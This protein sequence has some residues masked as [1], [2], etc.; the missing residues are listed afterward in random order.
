MM[1][2]GPHAGHRARPKP[3]AKMP[4]S[5]YLRKSRSTNAG[6]A[7]SQGSLADLRASQFS[8]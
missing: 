7:S 6:T 1:K 3:R 4:Q 2:F 8:R 5:R